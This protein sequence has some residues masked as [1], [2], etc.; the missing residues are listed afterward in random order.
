[1]SKNHKILAEAI[2]SAFANARGR[3][4]FQPDRPPR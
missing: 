1:M 2:K 3:N 4:S